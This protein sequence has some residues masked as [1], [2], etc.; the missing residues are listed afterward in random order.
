[1]SLETYFEF[2][3]LYAVNPQKICIELISN[4][5]NIQLLL[6]ANAM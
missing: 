3:Y 5:G 6:H 1:M 4:W 2:S